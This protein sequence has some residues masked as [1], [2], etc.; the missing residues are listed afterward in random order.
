MKASTSIL[1]AG[2]RVDHYIIR[3][4]LGGGGFSLVYL[5]ENEEDG[6]QVAIKEYMPSRMAKRLR[7]HSVVPLSEEKRNSFLGGRKLFF[8]EASILA[9]LKHDGIVNVLSF[10]RANGTVYMVMEY[11]QGRDLQEYITQNRGNLDEEFILTL[12]DP[13]LDALQMIHEQGFFHQ[14]LKPGNIHVRSGVRPLL[15]D[16]GAVQR[17]LVS[18]IYNPGQV[19]STGFSPVEQYQKNGYTGPW[20]DVYA[21]GATMRT[22]IEGHPPPDA[23]ERYTDDKMIPATTA[24]R[25]KYSH[26]L[27]KA[28]DWALEVDP[29]LRPQSI[30]EFR[31]ALPREKQERPTFGSRLLAR[32]PGRTLRKQG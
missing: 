27:L 20:T 31:Q 3:K 2:T 16:F 1:P 11:E 21:I 5:A 14:D 32:L 28:L 30:A 4:Q 18:R 26:D 9:T 13:L 17:R 24:F 12:F 22:C 19:T 8:Q 7:D 10:F 25:K 6:Q 23:M 15:L 29:E